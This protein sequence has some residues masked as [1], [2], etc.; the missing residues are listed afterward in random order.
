MTSV[1]RLPPEHLTW[2]V[3]PDRALFLN[4]RREK[5]T[6]FGVYQLLKKRIGLCTDSVASLRGRRI[7]P[8][9]LRHYDGR[10]PSQGRR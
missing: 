10:S 2:P 8:Y 7:H 1:T 6:R 9:T 4:L 5:L 3:E